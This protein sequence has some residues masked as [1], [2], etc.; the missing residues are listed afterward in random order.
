MDCWT[1]QRPDSRMS[2]SA[3]DLHQKR[4]VFWMP[5][6][7][8]QLRHGRS[9]RKV[10]CGRE[11]L[12]VP[13]PVSIERPTLLRVSALVGESGGRMQQLRRSR[14]CAES[15]SRFRAEGRSQFRSERQ[16]QQSGV[17]NK[18]RHGIE[19]QEQGKVTVMSK[20]GGSRPQLGPGPQLEDK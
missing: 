16:S 10:G 1:Q 18:A 3:L 20:V 9:N 15:Q 2:L 17:R 11:T 14:F 13:L 7:Y 12:G 5:D 19:A 6:Y 4:G 8:W